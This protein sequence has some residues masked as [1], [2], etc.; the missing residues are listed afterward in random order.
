MQELARRLNPLRFSQQFGIVIEP[1]QGYV[2]PPLVGIWARWPYFHNNS[3]PSLCA[4]LT[5]SEQRPKTYWAVEAQDPQN[6]FDWD[7]NGYPSQLSHGRAQ[8][9]TSKSG[10]SN[11][12]HDEGIFLEDGNELLTAEQKMDLIQFLKTL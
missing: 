5:R 11:M 3:A 1:Q 12:G 2:P 7:C 8:Y 6:D 10:L 4:V 9:D